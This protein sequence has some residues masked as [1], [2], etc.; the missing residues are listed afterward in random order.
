MGVKN[1]LVSCDATMGNTGFDCFNDFG[2]PAWFGFVERGYKL[3]TV[4]IAAAKAALEAKI[5]ANNKRQRLYPLGNI[6]QIT[7]NDEDIITQQFNTGATSVVRDG[8]YKTDVQW[9]QGGFCLLYALLQGN[10][11]NSPFFIATDNGYLI[12]TQ[13]AGEFMSPIK[14]NLAWAKKFSWSDGTNVAAYKMMLDYEPTQINKNVA[15]LDFSDDGG[16]GYFNDLMGLQSVT[17]SQG[18]ARALGVIKVEAKTSCDSVNMYDLYADELADADA[19]VAK[20]RL[21]G[22]VIAITSVVKN[23]TIFGWTITLNTADANYTATAGDILISMAGP[24]DLAALDVSGFES[25]ALAQ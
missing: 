8:N 13:A 22:N 24:T 25:N 11:K 19:W 7:P 23:A 1:V 4:S 6:V 16:L 20:N 18:A 3:T 10:G 15:F 14:P 21:T 5:L 2:M 12:G 9:V 17:I